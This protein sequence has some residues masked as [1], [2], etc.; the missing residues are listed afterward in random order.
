MDNIQLNNSRCENRIHKSNLWKFFRTLRVQANPIY[1]LLVASPVSHARIIINGRSGIV[2]PRIIAI[3]KFINSL[4]KMPS[5]DTYYTLS[6][7]VRYLTNNDIQAQGNFEAVHLSELSIDN[8]KT[9]FPSIV[10]YHCAEAKKNGESFDLSPQNIQRYK[11]KSRYIKE[12]QEIVLQ[13][14]Q[15]LETQESN[16]K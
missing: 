5:K 14:N 3:S 13:C 9:Y 2:A 8:I 15:L 6:I 16:L 10:A 7:S 4:S 12:L 1:C 11:F